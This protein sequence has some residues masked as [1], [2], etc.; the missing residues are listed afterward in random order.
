M[1]G[2]LTQT[3]Q[4]IYDSFNHIAEKYIKKRLSQQE[5]I[6]L[7]G[8]PEK[9]AVEKMIGSERIDAAMKEYYDFYHVRHNELAS[10]FPGTKEILAFLRSK[11]V[12]IALFTGKGRRTTEI[13]LEQFEIS[14]YF[15]VTVTG[16]DVDEFKPSGDGIRKIM[17]KF[18]LH[19]GDVLMVGDA[20]ADFRA[21]RESGVAIAS[22]LWDSYGKDE[23]LKLYPD[24]IF[25]EV[26]VFFDWLKEMYQ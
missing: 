15:D 8:P 2:T 4:L 3:N 25:H 6:A 5:I 17:N 1:D 11:G 20:V 9:E 22:V 7:F 14:S 23:V 19:P 13:T 16:D 24:F 18:S 12:L 21:S 10:I 26:R